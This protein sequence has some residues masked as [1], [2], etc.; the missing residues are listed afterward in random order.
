MF[1]FRKLARLPKKGS[2]L[3]MERVIKRQKY[4]LSGNRL[5]ILVNWYPK[6]WHVNPY[7]GLLNEQEKDKQHAQYKR[8]W[9]SQRGRAE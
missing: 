4:L 6:P 5:L 8:G 9:C 7:H 3:G 1:S 2:Q